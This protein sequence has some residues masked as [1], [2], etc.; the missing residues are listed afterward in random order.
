LTSQP[1]LLHIDSP[2]IICGDIHGQFFDLLRIFD[3]GGSPSQCPYLFLGD[4]VDRGP[5]SIE[6]I[7]YLFCLKIKFPDRIW[8][9]RGNHETTVPSDDGFYDEFRDRKIETTWY[10]IVEVFRW[11]PIAAVVG[12]RIFCVHGGISKKLEHLS[13]IRDLERPLDISEPGLLLDLLWSDPAEQGNGWRESS[14]RISWTYGPDV[15][16]DF[17]KREKL[18]LL[19]R[20]HQ[21]V[22]DGY[23]FPFGEIRNCVT[24][25]SASNYCG[26]ENYGAVMKVDGDLTC[27]FEYLEP[28]EGSG[29]TE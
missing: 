22:D 6:V 20:A 10:T 3:I 23:E 11:L 21:N 13:Q 28:L 4:Y 29:E 26:T 16:D 15:V 8:L 24:V 14:R 9:L 27:S 12:R 17:L 18:D 5:N 25:F 19:C 2:I 7:S 1:T